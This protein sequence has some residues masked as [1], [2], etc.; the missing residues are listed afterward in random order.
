MSERDAVVVVS[1]IANGVFDAC[2]ICRRCV[3][4]PRGRRILVERRE[5][6]THRRANIHQRVKPA[7]FSTLH[8]RLI[9][10]VRLFLLISLVIR[11]AIP[12][13][14]PSAST[15][16]GFSSAVFT[17]ALH[18]TLDLLVTGGRDSTVRVS[19]HPPCTSPSLRPRLLAFRL[20]LVPLTG[21]Y[22]LALASS[23]RARAEHHRARYCPANIH[24]FPSISLRDCNIAVAALGRA[25]QG[26]GPLLLRPYQHDWHCACQFL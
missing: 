12:S 21:Q 2:C 17:M 4:L 8:F 20:G 11:A 18:P 19:M 3:H 14:F 22:Q 15:H 9:S 6:A 1:A 10:F 26:S 13:S 5:R 24:Q 16:S 23:G 25:H 7:P